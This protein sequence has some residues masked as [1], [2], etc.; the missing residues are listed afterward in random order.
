MSALIL[1]GGL[2]A[3]L[4]GSLQS[5]ATDAS[6]ALFANLATALFCKVLR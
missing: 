2:L 5:G 1:I 6:S 3:V 4:P